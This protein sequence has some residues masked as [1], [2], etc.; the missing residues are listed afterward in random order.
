MVGSSKKKISARLGWLL[1]LV[2][3]VAT[4]LLASGGVASAH[5]NLVRSNPPADAVLPSGQAPRQVQLWFSE[6]PDPNYSQ[7][8]VLDIHS[9]VVS[10]GNL[11]VAPDDNQSLIESLKP[12]LP[13]GT[14]TVIWKTV[15]AVDGH[16][17]KSAFS[18]VVGAASPGGSNALILAGQSNAA[19]LPVGDDASNLSVW[20]VL[21]RWLNYLAEAMVVGCAAFGL[22]IWRFS[23]QRA[24]KAF[25]LD[26]ATL[27]YAA[28]IGWRRLVRLEDAA[29][30]LLV[31]GWLLDL[32]Y[33]LSVVTER[34]PLDFS[35]YGSPLADFALTSRF[36]Q[37]WLVRLGLIFLI[38]LALLFGR[39]VLTAPATEN[40][41]VMVKSKLN[42]K[43]RIVGSA[44][45]ASAKVTEEEAEAVS[46]PTQTVWLTSSSNSLYWRGWWILL[47]LAL[48]LQLT[49]S[50][51]AHA[52]GQ[53]ENVWLA[54][55]VDWL[56]LAATSFW[57]GG[58]VSLI[59]VL[60]IALAKLQAGSGNRTRVLA[61]LIPK[62]TTMAIISVAVLVLSGIYSGL[63]EVGSID[64]LFNT[65]YGQVLLAKVAIFVVVLLLAAVNLLQISPKMMRFAVGD[66]NKAGS[67]AA[68]RLQFKFRQSVALEGVLLLA[69]LVSVGVLTSLQPS[70]TSG[71][72]IA[73]HDLI[74][75]EAG[76][77][78][79]LRITPG[80]I[81]LNTYTL[82]ITD[83]NKKPITD[84]SLV[85]MRFT[86]V[87]MDMGETNVEMKAVGPSQPGV[88]QATSA[89]AAMVG[90]WKVQIVVQRS[91]QNEVDVPF[92]FQLK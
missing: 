42:S 21:V 76:L 52:A 37:I 11:R 33:Q 46:V 10:V 5:A 40:Q 61:C 49:T 59:L 86:M 83:V 70:N 66:G 38:W 58:I 25:Q 81:G 56:H 64:A 87:E 67:K 77:N 31:L 4:L 91:G 9:Q 1:T 12:N 75:T 71:A 6:Q 48:L 79:D 19:N 3:L 18:F 85:Q 35:L 36:G 84:A 72:D 53:P 24:Q 20:S 80:Q 13:D 41:L 82:K 34:S 47:V 43:P 68:G 74:Q 78:F 22:L 32:I 30:I 62:F 57:I 90:T 51:N 54:V 28:Q 60:P 27:S 89:T 65:L 44:S 7:I 55:G 8:Q 73:N 63:L 88:Y 2:L 92:Q 29:I 50:L 39:R 69:V 16:L 15:S 45:A 26:A 17:V 23:L 14:Y